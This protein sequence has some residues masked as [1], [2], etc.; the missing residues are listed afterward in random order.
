MAKTTGFLT[1]LALMTWGLLMFLPDD[2]VDFDVDEDGN[3]IP[4]A[5][6]PSV[7][8]G[9]SVE[10]HILRVPFVSAINNWADFFTKPLPAKQFVAMRDRMMNVPAVATTGGRCEERPLASSLGHGHVTLYSDQY[11]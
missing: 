11:L 8:K 3:P 7:K 9:E 5:E 6:G 10:D 2:L 1:Q 4:A